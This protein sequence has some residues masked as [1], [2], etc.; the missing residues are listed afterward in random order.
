MWVKEIDGDRKEGR[1]GGRESGKHGK[2][3]TLE[4]THLLVRCDAV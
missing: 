3:I 1:K 2:K 4:K